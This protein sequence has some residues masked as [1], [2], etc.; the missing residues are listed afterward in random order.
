M[1]FYG[2]GL[3]NNHSPFDIGFF[4]TSQKDTHVVSGFT[5][6]EDLTEHLNPGNGRCQFLCTH[7]DN[8]NRISGVGNSGF[9][10]S[11]HDR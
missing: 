1:W 2:T 6:I 3:A 8:L 5:A 10:P 4:D 11:Y 9:Y 7:P